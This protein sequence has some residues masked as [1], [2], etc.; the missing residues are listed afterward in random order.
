VLLFTQAGFVFDPETEAPESLVFLD[1][2]ELA[3]FRQ[4]KGRRP[5]RVQLVLTD[6]NKVQREKEWFGSQ[7]AGVVGVFDHHKKEY[8]VS[9]YSDSEVVV[10]DEGSASSCR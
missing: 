1:D 4:L 8:S 10:V 9:E 2:P 5:A 7:I 3:P 6:H